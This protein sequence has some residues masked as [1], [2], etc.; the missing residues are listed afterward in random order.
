MCKSSRL[1]GVIKIRE[2]INYLHNGSN[3]RCPASE[4]FYYKCIT[5]I[6]DRRAKVNNYFPAEV[7]RVTVYHSAIAW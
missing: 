7:K 5:M 3:T 2:A 4:S 1:D 6:D